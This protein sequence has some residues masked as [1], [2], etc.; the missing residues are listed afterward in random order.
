MRILDE[1]LLQDTPFV[2]VDLE[3]AERNIRRMGDL[4]RSAGVKLRPHTKTHKSPRFAREQLASGATGITTAKL[5]E[6]EVMA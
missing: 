1:E 4:A 2:A 3:V 5:G 6:A